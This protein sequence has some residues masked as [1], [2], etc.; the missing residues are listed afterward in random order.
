MS[1]EAWIAAAGLS[2]ITV[3]PVVGGYLL[4]WLRI[5]KLTEEVKALG[6]QLERDQAEHLRI[7][8]VLD[9]LPK[10]TTQIEELIKKVDGLAEADRRRV[11]G[12]ARHATELD[13]VK[14]RLAELTK[15][16]RE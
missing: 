2:I 3:G 7:W 15:P 4:I 16:A 13:R 5:G 11:E 9:V 14:N 12:C 6:K 1:P 10:V 8:A